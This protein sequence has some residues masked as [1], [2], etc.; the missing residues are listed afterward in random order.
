MSTPQGKNNAWL[1]ALGAGAAVVAL[2][3]G[4]HYLSG[5]G[6]ASSVNQCL[7]DVDALGPP[8]KEANGI[9][10]FNYYKDLFTVVGKHGRIRFADEKKELIQQRRKALKEGNNKKYNELVKDIIQKEEMQMGDLMQE[11]MDHLGISEQ[12]FMMTQ[13]TYMSNPQASQILMQASM[14]PSKDDAAPKLTKQ[15]TKEIFLDQEGKKMEAMKKMFSQPRSQ[16]GD[17]M[18]A[19]LEMMVEQAKMADEMFAQ[20]GIEEEEFT[21][22]LIYHNVMNDPEIMRIQMENMKKMGLGNMMGGFG[23]M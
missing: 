13:Q 15:K 23:G 10:A 19:M 4:Y 18:E 5:E 11:V 1:I 21:T 20:T 3:V 9:L 8:K 12:E 17:P 6:S 22:A 7:D 16:G 2:A 14:M